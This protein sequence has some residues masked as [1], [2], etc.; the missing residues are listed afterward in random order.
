M[1]VI[2]VIQSW[3]FSS[4]YSSHQFSSEIILMCWFAAQET[5]HIINVK[6]LC[7]IIFLKKPRHIFFKK[8]QKSLI[9]LKSKSFGIV[10]VFSV[11]WSNSKIGQKLYWPLT[12]E[13]YCGYLT[14]LEIVSL[15]SYHWSSPPGPSLL[16]P[17]VLLLLLLQSKYINLLLPIHTQIQCCEHLRHLMTCSRSIQVELGKW[18][19][20]EQL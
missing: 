13:Q 2:P 20:S 16:T 10:N 19:V 6:K 3:I 11:T 4:R 8:V 18:R 7:C 12:F 14:A 9:Y 1:Y 15:I 5:L 17:V